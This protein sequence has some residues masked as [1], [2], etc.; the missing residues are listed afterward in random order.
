MS[1]GWQPAQPRPW[2]AGNPGPPISGASAAV[3]VGAIVL[4]IAVSAS[5]A[6]SRRR[7]EEPLRNEMQARAVTFRT[8]V[9]VNDQRGP[10]YLTVRGDLF[11]VSDPIPLARFL[12]GHDYCYRAE[13]TTVEVVSGLWHEW[14]E[15]GGRPGTGI[16]PI[17]I[18]QRKMNRQIW[19]ALVHAGVYPI[20]PA[21]GR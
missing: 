6:W 14:I 10:L 7:R 1:Q 3:L 12:F 21:P 11:E 18:G 17:Q 9:G 20:G 19:D 16:A 15:I 4:I 2:L 8:R 5:V 13:D